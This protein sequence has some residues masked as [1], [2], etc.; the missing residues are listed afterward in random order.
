MAS[1]P[2]DALGLFF[3]TFREQPALGASG[4]HP[5]HIA[6]LKPAEL[7]GLYEK[8]VAFVEQRIWKEHRFDELLPLYQRLFR[9]MERLLLRQGGRK[10]HDFIIAIPVADRPQHLNTCLESLLELCHAYHYGGLENGRFARLSV[11]IADDSKTPESLR[12]HSEIAETFDR[13]GIETHYFGPEEQRATING[14]KERSEPGSDPIFGQIDPDAFYHKGASVTRNVAY[15]RLNEIGKNKE[16]PLFYFIDSDQ[17]FK[18]NIATASGERDLCAINYLYHLDRIFTDT[19]CHVLT[20]KVVGDPPVSPSVMAGN[21]L[22]D[23]IGFLEQIGLE[24]PDTPCGFHGDREQADDAAYHDMAEL[25]GFKPK[26]HHFRYGCDL[27]GP[28]RHADCLSRFAGKLA[29]FF[30]GEHPTR[31]SFYEYEPTSGSIT[32]ART[33]YTGNYLFDR[34]GLTYF[35]PFAPLKLRMAGPVLGRLIKAEIGDRFVSA[36]LP[37]L[38]K[39][40]VADT[41]RSEFRPGIL[42]EKH[43]TDLSGEFERQFFGD[44][45]LFSVERLTEQGY[46]KTLLTRQQI[47]DTVTRTE[48]ALHVK[49]ITK[50]RVI[51]EKLTKLRSLFDEQKSWWNRHDELSGSIQQVHGFIADIDQNFGPGAASYRLISDHAHK[52]Q[53][54]KQIVDALTSLSDAKLAWRSQLEDVSRDSARVDRSG[55]P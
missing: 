21:L 25:F 18:V 29:S 52:R 10:R 17:A 8:A 53:R 41:G 13:R 54:L 27:H 9:E 26:E 43:G 42:R 2:G 30:D 35:I 1:G 48:S 36:N 50:R 22:D 38:H 47:A 20:G 7:I 55:L 19:S 34:S 32:T 16:D 12:R 46:P 49:Y 39:R 44:V 11:L 14:F 24:S 23:I 4:I 31:R 3:S 5:E 37:M 45:M 33:V 40:T 28:H 15:L 51:R 6:G